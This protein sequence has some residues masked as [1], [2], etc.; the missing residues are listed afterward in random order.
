MKVSVA[1]ISLLLSSFVAADRLSF[2]GGGQKVLD[3]KGEAVPGK[4]P[5]VH[6]KADHT[7][8]ILVLD[9][10]DLTPNPPKP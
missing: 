1:L 10:V 6:C 4:N 5:L 2:F 9:H 8:E 7:S 3:D